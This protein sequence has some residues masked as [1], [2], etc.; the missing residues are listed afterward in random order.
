M[1][2]K[3][4]LGLL[5]VSLMISCKSQKEN[6]DKN[7]N[8]TVKIEEKKEAKFNIDEDQ[9]TY[10]KG[11]PTPANTLLVLSLPLIIE[12][13]NSNAVTSLILNFLLPASTI[14]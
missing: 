13:Q 10:F 1:K 11:L 4:I 6:V 7:G 2:F 3:I 9:Q 12:F 8:K 14:A 5:A